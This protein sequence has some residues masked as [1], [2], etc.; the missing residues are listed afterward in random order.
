MVAVTCVKRA[1]FKASYAIQAREL[2][3]LRDWRI[4]E[5]NPNRNRH[6]NRSRN[7]NPNRNRKP[8]PN[9]NL[10][11]DPDLDLIGSAH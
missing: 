10:N 3:F 9:T 6:L 7:P 2:S 1:Q 11:S 4:K 5:S 8:N